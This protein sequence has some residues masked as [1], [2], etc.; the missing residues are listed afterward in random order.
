MRARLTLARPFGERPEWGAWMALVACRI[1]GEKVVNTWANPVHFTGIAWAGGHG[2][3][4][5][6]AGEARDIP[7]AS[8]GDS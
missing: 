4:L 3:R 6:E 7:V 5:E 8:P 1:E 2:R